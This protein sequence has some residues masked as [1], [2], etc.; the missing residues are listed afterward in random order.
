MNV[1]NVTEHDMELV[2][3]DAYREQEA[4]YDR[5][6]RCIRSLATVFDLT[7]DEE[8]LNA[9]VQLLDEVATIENR[10]APVK[11]QWQRVGRKPGPEL[12]A[13][14]ER[15]TG[16]LEQLR[17]MT[18]QLE[19]AAL[20]QRSELAP[21]LDQMARGQQMRRAYGTRTDD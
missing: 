1:R 19:Q 14:L 2:L 13:Q 4:C 8:R 16:L 20:K 10:I 12:S 7:A 5:A 6:L 17:T 21:E 3:R 15:V 18:E 9:Y 11:E